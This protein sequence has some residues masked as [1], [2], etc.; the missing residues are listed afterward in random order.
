MPFPQKVLGILAMVV[1]CSGPL[2][3]MDTFPKMHAQNLLAHK[4]PICG[5]SPWNLDSLQDGTKSACQLLAGEDSKNVLHVMH[6]AHG[7][8]A[9]VNVILPIILHGV[10]V[11]AFL[12]TCKVDLHLN[13][14]SFA[15]DVNGN[16]VGL[17]GSF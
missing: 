9:H 12:L 1:D 17:D 7:N 6:N 2:P 15:M 10:I 11:H 5:M 13:S 4:M 3:N 8:L 16:H 14:P